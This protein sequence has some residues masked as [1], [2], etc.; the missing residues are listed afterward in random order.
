MRVGKRLGFG[1]IVESISL[2]I[3]KISLPCEKLEQALATS[4]RYPDTM[5]FIEVVRGNTAEGGY[6][7]GANQ[8]WF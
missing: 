3:L 2:A 5:R 1:A 4:D 8:D 6:H 7:D